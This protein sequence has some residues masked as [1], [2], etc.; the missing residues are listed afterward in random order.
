MKIPKIIHQIWSGIEEPLPEYFK[1]LANTWKE[2]HPTWEY[3]LWDN[4][5]MN[6]F[7]QEYYSEYWERYNNFKYNIQ[8]WDVIRYL[9]LNKKGGVYVDFDYESLSPI[10]PILHNQTCCFSSEP[11]AHAVLFK[12]KKYF[13]NALMASIPNHDFMR[14]VIRSIFDMKNMNIKYLNKMDEVLRTTG[15]LLLTKLYNEFDSKDTVYLIPARLVSPFS[16]K[17]VQLYLSNQ[18]DAK[19]E[20]YLERKLEKAIAIHYFLGGWLKDNR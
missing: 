15:P 3:I 13:N 8:R 17:D 5:M 11:K 1:I 7:I 14:M 6:T 9:I 18:V 16:K 12:D 4:Q 2:H 10:D 19:L 20:G